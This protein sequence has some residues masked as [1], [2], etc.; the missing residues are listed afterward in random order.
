[1]GANTGRT[2]SKW[3]TFVIGDS[4]NDTL[5]SIPTNSISIVGLAYA[6][7]DL[8]AYQD[9]VSNRLPGQPDAPVDIS[10][11]LDTSAATTVALGLSGSHTVLAPLVGA[12]TP[13]TLDVRFGIR[14]AYTTGEPQFGITATSTA[15]YICTS[16]SVTPSDMTYSASFRLYPGSTAPAWGTAGETT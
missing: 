15:G 1:M 5:R 14:Q 4:G 16:Y 3:I 7:Q 11:P 12:T 8:T 9:A 2:T 6:E 13:L 10:G